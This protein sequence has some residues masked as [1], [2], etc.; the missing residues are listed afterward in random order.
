[1]SVHPIQIVEILKRSEQGM[2]RPFICRCEDD[3]LYYVKG[4]GAGPRSLLC[5]WLAGHLANAL[6]LPVPEFV[7]AQASKELVDLFPDGGDLGA[8]PA[9]ASCSA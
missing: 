1:M 8:L 3:R 6:D 5:E 2:T 9:F 7:I 4:R